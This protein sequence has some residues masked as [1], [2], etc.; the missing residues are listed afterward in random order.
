[1]KAV[2]GSR[3]ATTQG[4][5]YMADL[6]YKKKILKY[7]KNTEQAPTLWN[8]FFRAVSLY[9]VNTWHWGSSGCTGYSEGLKAPEVCK[10]ECK[11]ASEWYHMCL[12]SSKS[13]HLG[14]QKP[15]VLV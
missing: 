1:M 11:P 2:K 9:T 4:S 10:G 13:R 3:S 5:S 8:F 15:Q 6:K 14:A 12:S 7:R